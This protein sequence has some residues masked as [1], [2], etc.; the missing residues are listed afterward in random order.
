MKDSFSIFINT[1]LKP[2]LTL[3]VPSPFQNNQRG[4]SEITE[5]LSLQ[6]LDYDSKLVARGNLILRGELGL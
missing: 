5:I 4:A 3:P 1:I 2:L 6:R